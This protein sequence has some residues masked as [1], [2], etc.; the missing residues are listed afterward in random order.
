MFFW[1]HLFDL[2]AKIAGVAIVLAVILGLD[3][4]VP[5]ESFWIVFAGAFVIAGFIW[6]TVFRPLS[7]WCY[8][9]IWLGT[10]LTFF[11]A[12]RASILFSPLI[13]LTK[14]HP[15]RQVRT[16]PVSERASAIVA[17]TDD[18]AA[19]YDARRR[20]WREAPTSGKAVR[21]FLWILLFGVLAGV[22]QNLPPF[23]WISA[24]QARLFGGSYYS[25]L[26]FMI[27]ALPIGIAFRVLERRLGIRS[28]DI[29]AWRPAGRNGKS[30][31]GSTKEDDEDF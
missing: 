24:L 19:Y 1:T 22:D 8:A 27:G 5:R 15:M 18:V 3:G 29:N 21:A 11:Q 4:V 14:W 26:T 25:I 17:A 31:P 6:W 13:N 23:S 2:I 12:Q 30:P 10:K 7:S 20:Q 9:R 28:L 16:L